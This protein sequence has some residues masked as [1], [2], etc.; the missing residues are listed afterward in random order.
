MIKLD[1]VGQQ[2]YGRLLYRSETRDGPG[3]VGYAYS[4]GLDGKRYALEY[5]DVMDPPA[6]GLAGSIHG[7]QIGKVV[8]L[9]NDPD[10]EDRI[11]VRV[12]VIDN[13]AQGI[14][15]ELPVLMQAKIVGPFFVPSSG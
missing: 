4:I 3:H 1:G 6:A 9:Q 14:W 5:D 11:L 7:L 8:Q 13:K 10:G 12:P 15:S 2:V